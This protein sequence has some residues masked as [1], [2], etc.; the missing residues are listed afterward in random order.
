MIKQLKRCVTCSAGRTPT[1]LIA[2]LGY[3]SAAINSETLTTEII[4]IK[5]NTILICNTDK[6]C[7]GRSIDVSDSY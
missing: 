1:E 5:G 2:N 7:K 6:D 4:I 3:D